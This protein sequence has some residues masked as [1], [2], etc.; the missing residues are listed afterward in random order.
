MSG[1]DLSPLDLGREWNNVGR[2]VIT[3]GVITGLEIDVEWSDVPRGGDLNNGTLLLNIQDDGNGN[4][5][6]VKVG[7]DEGFGNSVWTPCAP[8][9]LQVAEY[10]RAYGGEPH[11]YGVILTLDACGDLADL[12]E[13]VTT[14]LDTADAGSPDFQAALGYSHA[15]SERKLALDC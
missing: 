8:V 9:E 7:G 11:Q 10:V 13:T 14:A 2:G 5:Q 4:V 3:G 12:N 1:R 6:I 15:I